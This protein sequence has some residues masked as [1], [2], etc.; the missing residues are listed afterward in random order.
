MGLIK[1]LRFYRD[2]R[3]IFGQVRQATPLEG[4]RMRVRLSELPAST[5]AGGRGTFVLDE[6]TYQNGLSHIHDKR[7]VPSTTRKRVT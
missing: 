3:F 7:R 4:G 1:R 6:R 5:F 2:G